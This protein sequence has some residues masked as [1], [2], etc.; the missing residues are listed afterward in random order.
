MRLISHVLCED[1]LM[2]DEVSLQALWLEGELNKKF[3][4]FRWT[5]TKKNHDT[6]EII[7]WFDAPDGSIRTVMDVPIRELPD[8]LDYIGQ[9]AASCVAFEL[10]HAQ[11]HE[12]NTAIPFSV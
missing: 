3:F 11:K 1:E 4:R 7:A 12:E 10:I 9:E 2:H 8:M 6:F 5:V